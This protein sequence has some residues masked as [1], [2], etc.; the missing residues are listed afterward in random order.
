MKNIEIKCT[1]CNWHGEENEMLQYTDVDVKC[2]KCGATQGKLE[3]FVVP[4]YI[5]DCPVF[6]DWI[7]YYGKIYYAVLNWE[8]SEKIQKPVFDLA[9]CITKSF[10]E[11]WL[12]KGVVYSKRLKLSDRG[13]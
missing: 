7:T 2:P 13:N 6:D 4:Q 12:K 9:Y 8:E 5:T 3:D 1:D 10:N 11:V